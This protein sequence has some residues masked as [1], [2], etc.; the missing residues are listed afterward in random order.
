[1]DVLMI[2]KTAISL[3]IVNTLSFLKRHGVEFCLRLCFPMVQLQFT[4]ILVEH[5]AIIF[6]SSRLRN[7][8][9]NQAIGS[10]KKILNSEARRNMILRS[11]KV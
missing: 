5:T 3:C 8:S 6:K 11:V 10:S 7:R 9:S 1:M 2:L 4:D